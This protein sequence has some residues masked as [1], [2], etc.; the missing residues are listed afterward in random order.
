[1]R[2][3]HRVAVGTLIVAGLGA[4]GMTGHVQALQT[5]RSKQSAW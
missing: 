4:S 1:M 2:P 3:S 5:F